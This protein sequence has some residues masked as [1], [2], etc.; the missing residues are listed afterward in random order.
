[1]YMKIHKY[2]MI[3]KIVMNNIQ[4]YVTNFLNNDD[5]GFINCKKETDIVIEKD[6]CLECCFI[7][8]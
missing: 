2:G 6:T 3:K 8:K 1:M 4:S 7:K 5:D